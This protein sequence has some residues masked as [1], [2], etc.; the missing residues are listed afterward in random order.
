VTLRLI[1]VIALLA[2]IASIQP[3]EAA[4]CFTDACVGCVDDC[5]A[6]AENPRAMPAET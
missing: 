4:E 5:T 6:A 1:I 2:Y 3:E